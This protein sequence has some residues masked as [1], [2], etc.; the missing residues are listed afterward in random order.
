MVAPDTGAIACNLWIGHLKLELIDAQKHSG[1]ICMPR[2]DHDVVFAQG[3]PKWAIVWPGNA[4]G[5]Q[6]KPHQCWVTS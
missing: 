4:F 6:E 2:A 1:M 3:S 5:G